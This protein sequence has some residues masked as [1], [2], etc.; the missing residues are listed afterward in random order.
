MTRSVYDVAV[1]GAGPAGTIAAYECARGGL[2]TILL[3]KERLPRRKVCGGGLSSKSLSILPFSPESVMEQRT[4]SGWVAYGSARALEVDIPRP[5]MMVCRESF[6]A[7]LA[8]RAVA[9]GAGLIEG[10]DLGAVEHQGGA[11]TLVPRG[12]QKIDA[13]ILVAADGARSV[14]RRQLFPE[15]HPRTV[16]ALEARVVPAAWARERL[17]HRCVFDF[18]AVEGGY[19]WIF[20]KRDHFNVGVYRF[21]KTPGSRDLHA[22]LTSFL[23]SNP[24]LREA[25]IQDVAGALIPVSACA[26]SL[27]RE[28]VILVGD[29]AG[30]GDALY[31]EGIY[32][33]LQS[34]VE[35][36]ASVI[37]H[38]TG[39]APLAAYDSRVMHLRRQLQA[40][41][42]MAAFVYRF[43][44]FAF[45]RMAR[46]PSVYRLFSGVVTG[47]VSS[48][49]C[50]LKV[51]AA[52]PYW[53][54]ARRRRPAPL[55]NQ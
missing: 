37:A 14:V 23:G 1:V 4:V 7:F 54:V 3:E 39:D 22:V 41:A 12:G 10:F 49:E 50:L 33:A 48:S 46:S 9:A 43:P 2:R 17:S 8:N 13:R 21:L 26:G 6:D 55:P 51:S 24:F 20:P 32:H 44:H 30:L 27:V 11:V 42:A 38:L 5:G 19:G 36:A 53:L 18:G 16:A 25:R 31:G 40:A 45:E 15:S 47:E 52:A 35:A 29:A 28:G 34:G